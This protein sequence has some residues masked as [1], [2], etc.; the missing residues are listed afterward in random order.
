MDNRLRAI[1][2]QAIVLLGVLALGATLFHERALTHEAYREIEKSEILAALGTHVPNQFA[3]FRL[4]E[5]SGADT[6]VEL[7]P[8]FEDLSLD[9]P[10]LGR[11][12]LELQDLRHDDALVLG[13][14]DGAEALS[15][16]RVGR[17]ELSVR[18]RRGENLTQTYPV[19]IVLTRSGRFGFVA[20]DELAEQIRPYWGASR[21]ARN[22]VLGYDYWGIRGEDT[23]LA[24]RG[25]RHARVVT[26]PVVRVG[27]R[28][29]EGMVLLFIASF[30]SVGLI[31]ANARMALR[32]PAEAAARKEPWALA[33]WGVSEGSR[34]HDTLTISLQ[35]VVAP[36]SYAILLSAPAIVGLLA[37]WVLFRE[38]PG[39]A[40]FWF[41]A[42]L[43]P[44]GMIV[45]VSAM[46]GLFRLGVLLSAREIA[47]SGS[48]ALKK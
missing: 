25:S 10:G 42:S 21:R 37:C 2:K 35:R 45:S 32:D 44:L 18:N 7:W 33:D 43:I 6:D 36:M 29:A 48:S 24:V 30:V 31:A 34:W 22:K 8:L 38:A 46:A 26:L 1:R 12:H 4:L 16:Q 11:I 27:V 40:L 41:Q 3:V 5:L 9:F 13:L 15:E 20:E 28:V 17:F 47:A 23:Y 19:L 39:S 14:E